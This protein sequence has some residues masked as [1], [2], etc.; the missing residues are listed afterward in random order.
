MCVC[1]SVLVHVLTCVCDYVNEEGVRKHMV[2][3]R[4]YQGARRLKGTNHGYFRNED[5]S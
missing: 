3:G 4:I 1:V 2:Q 5:G